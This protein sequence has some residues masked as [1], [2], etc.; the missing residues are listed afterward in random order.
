[1]PSTDLDGTPI[2][3]LRPTEVAAGFGQDGGIHLPPKPFSPKLIDDEEV[4]PR[5]LRK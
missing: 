1:M 2:L 3:I 4:P 5:A